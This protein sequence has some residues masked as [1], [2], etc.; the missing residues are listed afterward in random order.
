[1][2]QTVYA[3]VLVII[4]IY[5]NYGML[6][7]TAFCRRMAPERLR[8]FLA[9]LLGGFYSLIIICPGISDSVISLSRIPALFV[10]AF[11]A[12]G[13]GNIKEYGK[14]VLLFVGI[15]M[16]FAGAMLLLWFFVCPQ[17]MYFNGGVVY[18]DIDALTLVLL[19]VGAYIL[20]RL[21]SLFTESKAPDSL[22]YNVELCFSGK[23]IL[24][25]GLYDSGNCLSDPFSGEGVIVVCIDAVK[26]IVSERIFDD[27]EQWKGEINYRLIPVKSLCGTGLLPSFRADRVKIKGL[28][29]EFTLE[30]PVIALCREKICGGEYGALLYSSVFDNISERKG[31]IYV[32]HN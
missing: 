1:M 29:S 31:E 24:C 15:N 7:L 8:I 28:E 19:T 14:T 9:S 11:L 2:N 32:L 12:F 6:L 18:F 25:R 10:M 22:V 13:F 21:I 20:I 27:P 16:V 17:N 4:N 30:S 26:N 23:S 5:I 3:D